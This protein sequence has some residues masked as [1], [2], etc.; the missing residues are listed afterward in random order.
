MSTETRIN[1][2]AWLTLLVLVLLTLWRWS[3]AQHLGLE[4][5]ADEA[6][7]WS[8]SLDPDWGYYSKPPMI[9]WLIYLGTSLFGD[10]EL[11]VR[12]ATFLVWPLTAWVVYLL[13]RRLYAGEAWAGQA[14]FISALACASLPMTS[15]GG[16]LVTTDG[17]LLLFWGLSLYFLLAALREGTWPLWLLAGA[18]AGLGL[19]SK[20]SMVFFAPS[21]LVFLLI[22]PKRRHWLFNAKP[23]VAAGIAFLILLPNLLWNAGHEYVSLQH[24]ADISQL[25][26]DLFHPAALFEFFL[27]Q[28]GVFGPLMML[29]L[30]MLVFQLR[31]LLKDERS[32]FLATF[33]IVPLL[34]FFGLS[35]LS[36][37]FANW[38]AFAYVSG[39][40]LVTVWCFSRDKRAWI[41]S[42]LALNLVIALAGY[43]YRDLAQLAGK[44]LTS[45]TDIYKRVSGFR[46]LGAAVARILAAHPNAKLVVDDRKSMASLLYYARP[47]SLDA[48]YLNPTN[49]I[50]DHYALTRDIRHH[51]DGQFILVSRYATTKSLTGRFA[52]VTPLS[53]IHISLYPDYA[54]DYRV[55]LVEDFQVP[56][57]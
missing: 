39:T 50:D 10:G 25:D 7:Y 37:A 6:Q 46:P 34:A 24:T 16:I 41:I 51:P 36:R 22:S 33:C 11:A 48:L 40:A 35:L 18:A 44:E 55:W 27:A 29:I 43:Y 5:Y 52:R 38:G 1:P 47:A 12:S 32:R 28:F 20:Y 49:H 8:W 13:V 54:L 17:P 57:P 14:A 3:V 19:I 30:L 31:S 23:Y 21:V 45:K 9:A 4:L 15:L 26:R 2:Y 56:M 42:A 53:P